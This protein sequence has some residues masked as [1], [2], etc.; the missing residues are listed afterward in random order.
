MAPLIEI[1]G[2]TKKYRIGREVITAVNDVSVSI[3]SGEFVCLLGPSGSGKTTFL[4]LVA[5]LDRPTRGDIFVKGLCINKIKEK[6]M[7]LFRRRFMA[8][9]FQSYNLVP[10]LT[11]LENV[12]M[13]LMFDGIS[14]FRRDRRAKELLAQIGLGRRLRNKPSEMSGGQQQ[15]V[16][17]ARALINDPKILYADE[18]TGNLDTR[19]TKEIMDILVERVREKGVTLVMVT[20]NARLTEHADR[21]I[22]MLDGR[23]QKIVDQ[24]NNTVEE[25]F[26]EEPEGPEEAETETTPADETEQTSEKGANQ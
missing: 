6:D 25:F 2:L 1:K 5:G 20:H 16:S 15:R 10:T 13:P 3:E 7:A 19:T 22:Y 8:F 24:Q 14:K 23:I 17:I 9:V 11:A 21:V 12:S 26:P 18:P 4:H